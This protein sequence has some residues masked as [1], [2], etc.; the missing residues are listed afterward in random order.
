MEEK[1]EEGSE[2]RWILLSKSST[3]FSFRL[4]A[5]DALCT[6]DGIDT[7]PAEVIQ[8]PQPISLMETQSSAY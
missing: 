2:M 8:Q 1:E 3:S 4:L 5:I 6:V 7:I